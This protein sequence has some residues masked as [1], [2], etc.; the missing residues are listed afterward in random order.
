MTSAECLAVQ[1]LKTPNHDDQEKNDQIDLSFAGGIQET[2]HHKCTIK[3]RGYSFSVALIE[4]SRK[5]FLEGG[6]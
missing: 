3:V 4:Y 6:I 2:S 1:N 5:I